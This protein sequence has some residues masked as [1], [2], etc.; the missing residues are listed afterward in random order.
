MRPTTPSTPCAR[1]RSLPAA[2]LGLALATAALAAT[3]MAG[4]HEL[5]ALQASPQDD[6]VQALDSLAHDAVESGATVGLGLGVYRDGEPVLSE[7]YGK[8]DVENGVQATD[9]TV[10]RVGSVTKQFTA[11]AILKLGEDGALSLDDPITEF[12]PDYPE[13]GRDITVH[14]LLNHTAGIPNYTDMEA[15]QELMR[16]DLGHDEM[17]D[18]FADEPLEF[19]PGESFAYS[20][21]GYYL[22][23]LV[24]E[25]ASGMAYDAYLQETFFEPLELGDTRYCWESPVIPNR[26]RGY[27]PAAAGEG[28][29]G[30]RN[31]DPVSMGQPYAA[32]A[33]CS[34]VRDLARWTEALHGGEVLAPESYDRMTTAAEMPEGAR[35]EYAYGLILSDLEGIGR[36]GH[37]GGI[38]G[39]NAQLTYY[40]DEEL[41]V[42]TL[43]NLGGSAADEV[44]ESAGQLVLGVE[45]PEVED[46]PLEEGAPQR[47]VGTYDVQVLELEIFEED[48][49]LMAQG[50]DQQAFRLLYQGDHEFRASFDPSVRLVFAVEDDRAESVTLHQAG[51]QFEGPR[52][53]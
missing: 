29:N 12:L 18:V 52:L 41:T 25:E 10:F 27:Q 26:A 42:V 28:E 14:H 5:D 7:G 39:F 16:H 6:P 35:M 1:R 36:I 51:A 33:L 49:E 34:S 45:M 50:E 24:I 37:G 2:A 20:N 17:L 48:G 11:A 3:P 38:P 43:V 53:R 4:A 9:S 19:E 15:W 30:I 21:S 32:G 40:P 13:P 23:G 8:A 22:L 46:L 44:A 31:A 47:Y